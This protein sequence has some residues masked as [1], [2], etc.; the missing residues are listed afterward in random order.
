MNAKNIKSLA[1]PQPPKLNH[2]NLFP[3]FGILLFLIFNILFTGCAHAVSSARKAYI[4][5]NDHGWIELTVVDK[6]IPAKQ[7]KE[8]ETPGE[9][10]PPTCH[11]NVQL[12]NESFLSETI[13]PAGKQPPYSVRTGY[14]FAVPEDQYLLKLQYSGCHGKQPLSQ[15]LSIEITESHVTPLQFDGTTLSAEHNVRDGEITLEEIDERLRKI[16]QAVGISAE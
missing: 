5:A 12:N 1:N 16:E 4:T 15:E 7:L 3:V 11:I 10:K 2:G 14:R 9:P 6:E 8:G 13:H